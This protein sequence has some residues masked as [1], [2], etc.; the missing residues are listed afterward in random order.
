MCVCVNKD[1]P[2]AELNRVSSFRG[3][4]RLTRKGVVL[5]LRVCVCE[6]L[7]F[8]EVI[9]R[10]MFFDSISIYYIVL[11]FFVWKKDVIC[12]RN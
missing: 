8:V 5:N 1:F 4:R 7:S 3:C 9:V 6:S 10:E 2:A 12:Y 11:M